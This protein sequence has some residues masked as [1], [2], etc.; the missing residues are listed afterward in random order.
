MDERELVRNAINTKDLEVIENLAKSP[1]VNVRAAIAENNY[2]PRE[3]VDLLAKDPVSNVVYVALNNKKCS[4]N[5]EMNKN[6]IKHKC[7]IC[8]K[9]RLT[10]VDNCINCKLEK[11]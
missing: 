2:T 9:D 7:V 8:N 1:Y 4:V 5:R 6:D 11:F 3:I 10:M